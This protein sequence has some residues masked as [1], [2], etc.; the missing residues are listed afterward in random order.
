MFFKNNKKE[1]EEIEVLK[2]EKMRLQEELNLRDEMLMLSQSEIVL[3]VSKEGSVVFKN[4]LASEMIQDERA[5]LE[6]LKSSTTE[7]NLNGCSGIVESKQLTNG[8][9]VYN[10]VKTDIKNAKD[11]TIM[12]KHQKAIKG[13][14]LDSQQSYMG[15]L[16]NLKEMQHESSIIADDS[17]DGLE[18]IID[19]SGNMDR[20]SVTMQETRLGAQALQERSL[21]ISNVVQLIEDI[22]DQ[23]NLLALNAAIE[24]ARA[25][26]QGRGFAVVADE[27]RKLAERTTK[28]TKEIAETIKAIQAEAKEADRSMNDAGIAVTQGMKL[29]DEVG[30][31]LATILE[32]A[33]NVSSQINQVAAASEEQS[34]TAEQ[35]SSNIEAI[36][37]VASESAAVVQQIATASEDLNRLTENLSE[38]VAQFK[39]DDNYGNFEN[40]LLE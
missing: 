17:K 13:S 16:K 14:L 6:A 7:I 27:V 34:A 38:I 29:N 25:G 4:S 40:R 32:S 30:E 15:M 19:S 23:T 26:E 18:L 21:E 33:E 1:L 20:L 31:V 9:M 39:M 24:A 22:A 28:A 8:D 35:V 37:N 3:R 2:L 5:L 36:N 11:S 10:I 12:S